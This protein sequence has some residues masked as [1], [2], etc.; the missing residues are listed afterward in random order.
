MS[1]PHLTSPHLVLAQRRRP[2]DR[3]HSIKERCRWQPGDASNCERC[4]RLNFSCRSDRRF[5]KKG[6][7]AR[8]ATG[9]RL[10]LRRTEIDIPYE[11]PQL[12][13]PIS[14]TESLVTSTSSSA[15]FSP[16]VDFETSDNEY[17]IE[18]D[19]GISIFPDLTG[20]E[21]RLLDT[22]L[23]R[24]IDVDKYL[25]GPSFR[26]QHCQTFI[27]HLRIGMPLVKDAFIACATLLV[28]KEDSQLVPYR[29]IG[30]R[31]AAAAVASL[32]ELQIYDSRDVSIVLIFGMA[33]V[34]F[35][36]HHL[37]GEAS[38]CRHVLGL[39]KPLYESDFSLMKRLGSDGTS[40]LI[41]LLGTETTICLLQC[42]VPSIRLREDDFEQ[43]VDRFIGVSVSMLTYMYDICQ[44]A[45]LIR[46]SQCR[47]GNLL[48][49]E[50]IHR[51]L[52]KT[53]IA[54]EE[55]QPSVPKDFLDGRFTPAEVVLMLTQAKVL[56][57]TTSLIIHRLRYAF[58]TYG[59]K[60]KAIS[61]AILDELTLV[62]RLTGRSMPFADITF[63]V[64]C[65]EITNSEERAA[66]LMRSRRIV[67]FSDRTHDEIESWLISFWNIM[68]N[69]N[70][71]AIYWDGI[72]PIIFGGAQKL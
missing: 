60:A 32:R 71:P 66:A 61:R 17:A 27:D 29:G 1:H 16:G 19:R 68:D 6:R 2:C 23:H 14:S 33:M 4:S 44:L 39:V 42:Q 54:V 64:A 48:M 67:D 35:A 72:G 7:K 15:A 26:E 22:M 3:C 62:L 59:G 20:F 58:G 65:L 51:A 10:V 52:A 8:L 28:S 70:C 45:H 12:S 50:G 38:V 13:S 47:L 37:G 69:E 63:F 53:E 57:L 31:R 41:C 9:N 49:D 18:I 24:Q 5:A 43:L 25:I 34:T 11:T 30:Y 21:F 55:W 36:L 46:Q 40:F 56:R